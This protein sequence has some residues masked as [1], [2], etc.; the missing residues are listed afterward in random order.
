MHSCQNAVIKTL[1]CPKPFLSLQSE[2]TCLLASICISHFLPYPSSSHTL[3]QHHWASSSL[4]PFPTSSFSLWH[5]YLV[6]VHWVPGAGCW[7]QLQTKH[8][9]IL[10]SLE[11][12]TNM[13]RL[14]VKKCTNKT[15]HRSHGQKQSKEGWWWGML[16]GAGWAESNL[17]GIVSSQGDRH[18]SRELKLREEL[19]KSF[20]AEEKIESA[21]CWV[22]SSERP[23]RLEQSEG[24]E[25]SGRKWVREPRPDEETLGS[26]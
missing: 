23:V 16:A 6:N 24:K 2:S 15:K 10:A 19:R 14:A 26:Q 21:R 7:I 9:R 5:K 8:T 13:G 1:T 17:H 12:T 25:V 4:G 20:W 22:R 11:M 3:L 18:F